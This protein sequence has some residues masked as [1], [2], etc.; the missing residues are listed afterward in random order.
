MGFLDKLRNNPSPQEEITK[1]GFEVSD[2]S[3]ECDSCNFNF[4]KN[5]Q[6]DSGDLW[7]STKPFG[8][9]IVIPTNKSDWE[10][11]AVNE[12]K[13]FSRK[14]NSWIGDQKFQ[15]M[16][17][18]TVKVNVSSQCTEGFDNHD[19]DYLSGAKGDILILPQF[20]WV[21]NLHVDD[22]NDKLHNVIQ[23]IIDNKVNDIK[24]SGDYKISEDSNQS[25]M[26]LCSH[27]TRDKRCGITA[28]IMKKEIDLY[29]R[30]LGFYR[31]FGDDRPDGIKV[32]FINHIG[33]HKFVANLLIYVKN[34]NKFIWL[35]RCSPINVK[36]IVDEC[37]LKGK[38]FPEN[39]RLIQNFEL[40]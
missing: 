18:S 37:V 2:C 4:P 8:L 9:H 33:G 13:S 17:D 22:L 3:F 16:I 19:P 7:N 20:V 31:D 26:F 34:Q 12:R 23:M 30:D 6:A 29:T 39:T 14:V 5:V 27:R 10:H 32:D 38:V 15:N 21:K 25:Y 24:I 28:P 36:S 35:A 40:F 11:D 1:K